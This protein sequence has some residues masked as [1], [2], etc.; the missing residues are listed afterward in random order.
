VVTKTITTEI[1]E[2]VVAKS[3]GVKMADDLKGANFEVEVK[4][5]SLIRWITK[6][7]QKDE[8]IRLSE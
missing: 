3:S 5:S 6:A 4:G 1:D 2:Y 8:I 7:L